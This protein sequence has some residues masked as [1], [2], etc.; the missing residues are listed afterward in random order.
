MAHRT[1][2]VP[3][4]ANSTSF[5]TDDGI[6]MVDCGVVQVG[7]HIHTQV[8]GY[9]KEPLN[10]VIYT[11]GHVDHCMGLAP[12]LEEGKPHVVAHENVPPRFVR[13]LRTVGLQEHINRACVGVL[14]FRS[15]CHGHDRQVRL[16][17]GETLQGFR[18]VFAARV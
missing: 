14:L 6:V 15:C 2:H 12:W 1:F 18:A 16:K 11:H 10:T 17:G 13:Y 5:V 3:T 7:P 9:T 4:M 8:R